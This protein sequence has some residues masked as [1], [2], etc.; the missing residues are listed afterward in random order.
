MKK[1]LI[2][3]LLAFS[4]PAFAQTVNLDCTSINW[5]EQSAATEKLKTICNPQ[6]AK[7]TPAVTPEK[8][9]EWGSLGKEFSTAVVDTARELGVAVNEFLY[10]PVGILIAFYFLW[11]LIGGIIIGVPV[12]IFIWWL[13]FTICRK[14]VYPVI[15][16]EYEFVP[17]LLGLISIKRVKLERAKPK[18]NEYSSGDMTWVWPVFA[19]PA[20]FLSIITLAFLIF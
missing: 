12:L 18:R 2:P 6:A 16:R 7:E 8:V 10:T 1:I 17:Y 9:R 13:Y 11:G 5:T 15:D 4:S 19:I 14:L 3:L 20:L